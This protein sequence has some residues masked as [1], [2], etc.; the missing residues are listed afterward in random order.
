MAKASAFTHKAMLYPAPES[1]CIAFDSS[2]IS[3]SSNFCLAVKP[4]FSDWMLFMYLALTSHLPSK[5]LVSHQAL[6][7]GGGR[8][9]E[10]L[11]VQERILYK[12][13]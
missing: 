7:W 6:L 13:L 10:G 3:L 9:G 1:D 4:L 5:P 12:M 8:A 11:F 2:D